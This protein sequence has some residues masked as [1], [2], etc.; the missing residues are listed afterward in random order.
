ME[1]LVSKQAES[2]LFVKLQGTSLEG[3]RRMS[4]KSFNNCIMFHLLTAFP[5]NAAEREKYY[6]TNLLKKPQRINVRQFV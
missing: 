2:D 5:I 3:P 6:V 1:N 4:H